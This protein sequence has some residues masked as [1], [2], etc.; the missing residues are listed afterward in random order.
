MLKGS[1][2]IRSWFIISQRA[3]SWW[4]WQL[5]EGLIE[6]GST[7]T[8]LDMVRRSRCIGVVVPETVAVSE[9]SVLSIFGYPMRQKL[10]TYGSLVPQDRPLS[11]PGEHFLALLHE[12][13]S[14]PSV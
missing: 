2:P 11:K 7:L 5:P 13:C 3:T 6:T 14:A 12:E 8:T 4:H 1:G 9:R 10:E